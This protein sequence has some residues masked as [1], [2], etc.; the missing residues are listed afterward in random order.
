MRFIIIQSA[1]MLNRFLRVFCLSALGWMAQP[2]YASVTEYFNSL[3]A[4]PPALYEFLKA[5][6]K[7]GELH[8]HFDG[9]VYAESMLYLAKIT[10]VCIDPSTQASEPCQL[11][12]PGIS[13]P[14]VLKHPQLFDKTV[15][16][17]SM[18]D[19]SVNIQEAYQHFHEIF[20]KIFFIQS[21]IQAPLL[22]AVLNKAASQHEQY[23]EMISFG[24]PDNQ[25]FSQSIAGAKSFDQKRQRLLANPAFQHYVDHLVMQSQSLL[26]AARAVLHCADHPK[27]AACQ[28]EVAYQYYVRRVR[29]IDTVFADALLGFVAAQRSD[30]ILAVNLVDVEDDPVAQHDYEQQMRIFE[31]LHHCYPEVHIAL[32]AGELFPKAIS[33][34]LVASPIRDAIQIGHAERIGHG[35]DILEEPD[36]EGLAQLM[37]KQHIPVEVNLSSNRLLLGVFGG[38]HPLPYYLKHRVPL[39]LSTDDE[40]ILRTEL[41]QEYYTAVRDYHL[42]YFTLKTIDRN[43]LTYAFIP[44]SSLWLDPDEAKPVKDCENDLS[45]SC[46]KFIQGNPKA[47]LQ[48]RLEQ[49]FKAFEQGFNHPAS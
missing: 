39:V 3:Q 30:T 35:V 22:A 9:S 33:P 10:H 2:S 44:G 49:A 41:T 38:K 23:L 27:D 5:M 21:Q 6:P 13:I 48:W 17:W 7:G 19:P 47:K 28:I 43:S 1:D 24:L 45:P 20:P 31:Y 14:D 34:H 37:A 40:G 46:Y 8:Y 29:L 25:P 4:N 16:A 36:P 42:D 15:H 11:E 18:K 12:T 32:H 26:P